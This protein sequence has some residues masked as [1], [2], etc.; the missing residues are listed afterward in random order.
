MKQVDRGT[1]ELLEKTS[2]LSEKYFSEQQ[3]VVK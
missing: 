2:K 1:Q 3:E